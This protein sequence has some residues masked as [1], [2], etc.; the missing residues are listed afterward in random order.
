MQTSRKLYIIATPIG[1]LEDMTLRAIRILKEVDCVYCEDTRTS[2]IL[3]KHYEID[4]PR[5]SYHTHSGENKENEILSR[6][7]KGES[8]ALITDAGTP[9]ISDPGVMLIKKVIEEFGHETV[10][11]IPGASALI[12]ALSASGVDTS[13]FVFLGFMPHKKGRKTKT[14]EALSMDRTVIFYESTHRIEKLL[15]EIKSVN[16][17]KK[18]I[19]A[20]EL[21][22]H[23]EEF[24][25]GTAEEIL[26]IFKN[27]PEKMKGEFV[28]IIEK[29]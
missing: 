16:N 25:E 26:E 28:V 27:T 12:S 4:T 1:N 29:Q 21:T 20:R 7:E 8:L 11:P 5:K 18:I 17:T 6:L 14:E 3:L 2:G 22:K 10:S 15:E 13:E 9:G 23:F 19:L 24:L